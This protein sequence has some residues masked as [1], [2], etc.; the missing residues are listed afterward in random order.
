MFWPNSHS[1]RKLCKTIYTLLLQIGLMMS[2]YRASGARRMKRRILS[3]TWSFV[4]SENVQLL[5]QMSHQ[6]ILTSRIRSKCV[7]VASV[8]TGEVKSSNDA[9][10]LLNT[11]LPNTVKLISSHQ[12]FIPAFR[13]SILSLIINCDT[14]NYWKTVA[15]RK[16]HV[17]C[18]IMLC[19]LTNMT[20]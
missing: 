6:K 15:L 8:T 1:F 11:T 9:T 4:I 13:W 14:H 5:H 7:H 12:R 17:F 20:H 16:W 18:V 2:A 10:Q 3:S 19:I